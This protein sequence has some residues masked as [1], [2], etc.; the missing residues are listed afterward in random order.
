[1]S[2]SFMGSPW[3]SIWWPTSLESIMINTKL[4]CMF[5]RRSQLDS[6]HWTWIIYIN[7]LSSI[8]TILFNIL[9]WDFWCQLEEIRFVKT[10]SKLRMIVSF[11]KIS[12][13][14]LLHRLIKFNKIYWEK[15]PAK[16]RPNL[17][18]SFWRRDLKNT[19]HHINTRVWS[20]RSDHVK[21]YFQKLDFPSSPWLILRVYF[22]RDNKHLETYSSRCK[23][24][25][26]SVLQLELLEIFFAIHMFDDWNRARRYGLLWG[27]GKR[28]YLPLRSHASEAASI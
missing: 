26:M 10:L 3:H 1:M 18:T 28:Q 17:R 22:T 21:R 14:W 2:R 12:A 24:L 9:A 4:Y 13:C 15:R 19:Q 16:P 5:W 6:R 27:L 23:V 11:I 7:D 25:W 8:K 20:S